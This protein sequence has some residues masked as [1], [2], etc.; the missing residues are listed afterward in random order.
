MIDSKKVMKGLECCVRSNTDCDCPEECPYYEICWDDHDGT[1]MGTILMSDALELL[2]EQGPKRVV[3]TTD[4]Y[5]TMFYH[6]PRCNHTFY[7][8]PR[9]IYCSQCGQAVKWDG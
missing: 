9:Q 4:S 1:L 5:G 6:C 2:K 3:K 8:Y 7:G